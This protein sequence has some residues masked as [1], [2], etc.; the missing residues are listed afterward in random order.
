M[1]DS[2]LRPLLDEPL[3]YFSSEEIHVFPIPTQGNVYTLAELPK[4]CYKSGNFLMMACLER[5][6]YFMKL[7][8]VVI[9]IN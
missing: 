7:T 2:D 4:D 1:D 9:M 6:I 5:P 8:D 3:I